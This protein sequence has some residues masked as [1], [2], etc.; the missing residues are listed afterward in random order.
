MGLRQAGFDVLWANDKLQYAGEVHKA[1][2]P[3]T[4]FHSGDIAKIEHFP[5]ADLLVGCYP[6][7]G[8]SQAGSRQADKGINFLYRQFDRALRQ[9]KPK[10]FIVENVSGMRRSDLRHLL[11]N[12]VRRF[13]LAGYRVEFDVLNAMDY[14]VAQSRE[15]IFL[16]GIRSDQGIRYKFPEPTHGEGKK[17]YRTLGETIRHLPEWPEGEYFEDVFHWYYLSRNRYRGWDEVSRTIV[18]KARHAPLHPVSPK[19]Q[20]IH[21]DKWVFESD[22]PARRISYREAALIQG[23]PDDFVFP[24]GNLTAK[25]TVIGNAVPPPLFREIAQNLPKVW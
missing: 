5:S 13:R 21:T 9:I 23:F 1:N 11:Q 2:F 20:R 22:K 12:Q 17:A 4:E 14:G 25:Y 18:A 16:V 6:C 10:A 8:F 3:E 15:R 19:L 7:Q 24:E